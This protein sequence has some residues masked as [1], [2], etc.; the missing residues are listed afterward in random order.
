MWRQW[1]ASVGPVS[2]NAGDI[3]NVQI[4][5]QVPFRVE[6]VMGTD[7]GNPAGTATRIL[8]FVVGQRNQRP[9][10]QG[11]SS[12]VFFAPMALGNG[13]RWDTCQP[14][15]LITVQ[16]S[17]VQAATFDMDLFGSAVI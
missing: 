2:G 11:S 10:A 3:K 5:P 7:T 6:K 4:S 16:V 12:L 15:Q 13:V 14:G 8:S 1:S 17:F 9:T